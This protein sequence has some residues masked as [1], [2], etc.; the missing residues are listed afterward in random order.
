MTGSNPHFT[1]SIICLF[2]LL[3]FAPGLFAAV[4]IQGN[5]FQGAGAA[6]ARVKLLTA[7]E[8]YL[9]T[10]YRYAG[11]DRRG[12]DCSGLVFLS[13]REG[14]K[15]TIPRTAEGIYNWTE[16]IATSELAPGDLVFFVTTGSAVSHVGIYTGEG[17]FIHSASD[18]PQTGVMY[19]Q[20]DESYWKRTYKGAGRALPWDEGTARAMASARTGGAVR[21][22]GTASARPSGTGAAAGS[23]ISR[24]TWKDPGFFAGLGAD[25]IWGGIFEGASSSFRGI[26][27]LITVGYKW[28]SY[29]A[30]LEL[31]PQWDNALGV[32]RLPFMLSFGTDTFQVFG[33]PAYTFG[34]PSLELRGEKRRHKGGGALLWEAGISGAFPPIRIG[35]GALSFCG[36][37]A[38]QPYRWE[39][40]VGYSFKPE[41]AANLRVSTGIHYLWRLASK[42]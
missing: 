24:P 22:E 4:P 39:D 18:G 2:G 14:L 25:W 19:S 7:A 28:P 11:H 16:K 30:G 33:G 32:F 9:G 13:F 20:L 5:A 12:L 41:L 27:T 42:K 3:F 31:R 23:V 1:G 15:Y 21:Q 34:E 36:E 29:R 6:E 26:S 17:R 35:P 37:L 10:P 40:G 8:S 38:W